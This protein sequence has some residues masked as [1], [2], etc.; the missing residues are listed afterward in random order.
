MKIM[1]KILIL[2]I[3]LGY[4]LAMFP[5][6]AL[7]KVSIKKQ[8][9]GTFL[10]VVLCGDEYS[11]FFM[12]LD[13]IPVFD[14][15]LGF[16][17]G[18]LNNDSILISRD[19]A[20]N[21]SVRTD[22][23]KKYF[24]SKDAIKNFLMRNHD[25]R[26]D[27]ENL[28]RIKMSML[29]RSLGVPKTFVGGKKGL[30]ILVNFANLSM[31][32][33]DAHGEFDALFNKE[34]YSKNGSVGSVHD[35][36]YDQSYGKFNLAFD[37]V[38]PVTVSR[39]YGYYGANSEISGSDKRAYEMIIEAC[40]LVDDKVNFKDYDWD[41]DGEVDQVFVIYAGY[42]EHAGAPSNTIWPHESSLGNR[43]IM[44]DGVRINTYACSSELNGNSGQVMAGIGTPCHEFSHCLGFPDLYDT[45]YSGAFGM[46]YWDVMNSGSHSGPKNNGE[47]PY[48]Y[49]AY[50]R[51]LAGW[52]EMKEISSTQHIDA[53]PNLEE[54]PEAYIVY[55]EG[56]KNEYYILE[57][58]QPSKWFKYVRN[59]TD[60]HG[61]MV[62][63]VDYDQRAWANNVVNP[64][65]KHQRMSIIPADNR[66]GE[67]EQELRGDLFPGSNNVQWLT[68]DSHVNVGGHLFNENTDGSYRMN[69][70]IG[71]VSEN[72]DGSIS[73]DIVFSE[74]V[75][76]P[77][78]K[79]ITEI[80]DNGYTLNWVAVPNA[81]YYIVEQNSYKI[82]ANFIP[83][84]KKQTV[85]K[86]LDTS[87]RL[88]WLTNGTTN[89]HVKSVVNGFE[90]DWSEL[91]EVPKLSNG[92]NVIM[93]ET[94]SLQEY[95]S[96]DGI[97]L[98][99]PRKG[100]VLMK[101]N[102]KVKKYFVTH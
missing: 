83:T 35:Y 4:G 21:R 6:P 89:V 55:N 1:K 18:S 15:S 102:G 95:Y 79:D 64:N 100:L 63:H 68:N 91:L 62:T 27:N 48:G 26:Q 10:D 86:V 85:D 84:I 9:D 25:D 93:N 96:L 78:V 90:S 56:N 101:K 7:K 54:T 37:V 60:M 45:D 44:L 51:W 43:S 16:C 59:Y 19:L 17:Y 73:M 52:L 66:Y 20:H 61:L 11:H 77:V 80:D 40:Q 92:I 13:S 46:S 41:G 72:S 65:A 34:G 29:S 22:R 49:S 88:D 33:S 24:D 38:G 74:D 75:P 2:I 3:L 50:E 58:H 32:S 70:I 23:E 69:R 97:R 28:R 76:T 94:S 8:S 82:S 98:K 53:L 67:T 5:I 87:L 81:E 71:N 42:G 14:T 36:F 47:V 31:A 99:Q 30:V 39:N 57:N 12:T